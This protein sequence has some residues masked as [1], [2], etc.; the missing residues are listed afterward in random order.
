MAV[1]GVSLV[2]HPALMF[3]QVTRGYIAMLNSELK[4]KEKQIVIFRELY[5]SESVIQAFK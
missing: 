2:I 3:Q 5:S 1:G 4:K